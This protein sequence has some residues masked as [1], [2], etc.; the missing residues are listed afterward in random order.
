[1]C[2][3]GFGSDLRPLWLQGD[4]PRS[5]KRRSGFLLRPLRREGGRR[6]TQG[7]SLI[8]GSMSATSKRRCS[9]R[10][11]VLA[12]VLAVALGSALSSPANAR[13]WRS[14]AYYYP[15]YGYPSYYYAPDYGTYVAPSSSYYYVPG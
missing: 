9:M 15:T 3:Q 14:R 13:P 7:P 11:F 12:T 2:H 5:G 10:K 8:S 6:G 4:R 1:M